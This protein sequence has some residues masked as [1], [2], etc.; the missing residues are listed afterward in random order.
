M[1]VGIDHR[2]DGLVRVLSKKRK[3]VC[4]GSGK[5][6]CVYHDDPV[7]RFDKAEIRVPHKFGT[8]HT[9][10][11]LLKAGNQ[12]GLVRQNLGVNSLIGRRCDDLRKCVGRQ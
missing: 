12:S 9:R 3:G 8:K 2:N 5:P 6:A 10:S 4:G 1:K 11:Q 7:I